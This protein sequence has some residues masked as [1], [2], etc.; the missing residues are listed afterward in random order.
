MYTLE[1][2]VKEL[3]NDKNLER[4]INTLVFDYTRFRDKS[5]YGRVGLVCEFKN[6]D[7]FE[8]ANISTTTRRPNAITV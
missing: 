4:A 2:T 1:D 7:I 5:R 8:L 3:E 6:G